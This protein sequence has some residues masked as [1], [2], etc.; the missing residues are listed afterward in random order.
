[1]P[2]GF[3]VRPVIHQPPP[4]RAEAGKRGDVRA[5]LGSSQ[6]PDDVVVRDSSTTV[7]RQ[8]FDQANPQAPKA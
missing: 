5:P 4:P 8:G 2:K 6:R 1:M 7:T 3:D